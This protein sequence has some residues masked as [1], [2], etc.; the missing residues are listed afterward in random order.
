MRIRSGIVLIED[1]KIALI[2]RFRAGRHYF[3]FPGGGVDQGETPEQ[4]AVREAM[5]ELGI[6]VAI[7]QMVAEILVNGRRQHYFLVERV[8]GDFGSGTGEEFTDSHPDDPETGVYIPIWMP[9]EELSTRDNVFPVDLA[10]LVYTT[11]L[12]G[13]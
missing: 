7:K 4:A 8:G 3:A 6:E 10:K 1:N 13:G 12:V 9:L 11:F 5:E 2:E